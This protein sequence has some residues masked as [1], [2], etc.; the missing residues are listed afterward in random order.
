MPRA[1]R[2]KT[3]ATKTKK[4]TGSRVSH[5][6]TWRGT[7]S[8]GLVSFAVE[9]FQAMNRE[10]S[11]IHFNQLHEDCHSRIKYKKVCPIHGEV[12]NDEIISGYE[13]SKGKYVEIEPDELDGLRTA[14]EKSLRI[15]A[16]VDTDTIDP[17]YFDGRMYYV[18]PAGAAA[19]E[20]YMVFLEAMEKEDR[21]A[22]GQFVMSGKDQ[23]ALL[24][25]L[26]GVLHMAM[27]N[28]E[29]EIVSPKKMAA[30]LPKPKSIARQVRL[31]Q[32]LIEDWSSEEF[33]FAEFQD[34]YRER[35]EELIEAKVEGREVVSPPEEDE[36]PE[37]VNLMEAL[38]RSL[39]EAR[40]K[41][42]GKKRGSHS[43]SA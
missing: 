15:E 41:S 25:P 13:Y 19:A 21:C 27:L 14:N 28:Y 38:R 2:K 4:K 31:A 42:R 16:F 12:S 6:A 37:V 26:E 11:D 20:P 23:I 29:A 8:F 30:E 17:I 18:L 3:T 5:R 40:S 24:R 39:S 1:A 36:E 32:T 35:V 7:L 33:D 9:T 43:R 22:V 10:R 34:H